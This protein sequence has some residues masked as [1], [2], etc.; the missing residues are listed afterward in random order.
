MAS[1]GISKLTLVRNVLDY[2]FSVAR[3]VIIGAVVL[4]PYLVIGLCWSATRSELTSSLHGFDLV[5]SFLGSVVAWPVL[6]WTH[7][8]MPST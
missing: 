6:M 1:Q 4:V 3:L 2:Q 8:G 5:L 7:A